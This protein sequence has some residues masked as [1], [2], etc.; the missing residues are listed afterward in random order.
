MVGDNTWRCRAANI[1]GSDDRV[2]IFRVLGLSPDFTH[3]SYAHGHNFR[4]TRRTHTLLYKVG[5]VYAHSIK[6]PCF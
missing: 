5:Y 2:I 1:A 6:E 4:G 3:V